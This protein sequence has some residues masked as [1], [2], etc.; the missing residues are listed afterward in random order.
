MTQDRTEKLIAV[1]RSER[2]DLATAV[3]DV[4]NQCL[5]FFNAVQPQIAFDASKSYLV[6]W[7][8]N[9]I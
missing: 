7:K 8:G 4:A 5:R 2:I 3:A 1:L 6:R 9:H